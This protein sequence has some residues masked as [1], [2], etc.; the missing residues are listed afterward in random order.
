MTNGIL[1]LTAYLLGGVPCGLIIAKTFYHV[2]VRERGSGNTG[3]TN[4]WRTL[5]KKPGMATLALDILKGAIPVLAA[6][7]FLP[8][9]ETTPIWAGVAAVV[10]H[11]WSPFLKFKGGKGVA[12]S[13]GA[14][15]ALYPL[16]A[17]LAVAAFAL[18]FFTTRHVSVGSMAGALTLF[19][20]SFIFPLNRTAQLVILLASAMILLKH[21]P[22]MKRLANG[23]EPKVNF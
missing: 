13:A 11:N 18:L 16:H 19:V 4:V 1:I 14:F 17:G 3:A 9:D 8:G 20:S 22:N 7:A 6:R 15:L 10:G 2:D 21:F 23:T 12:T 5:G